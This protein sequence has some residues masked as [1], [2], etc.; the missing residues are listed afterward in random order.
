MKKVVVL[1]A[2]GSI[3]QQALDIIKSNPNEFE[4]VK[5]SIGKNVKKL[6]DILEI[7]PSIKEVALMEEEFI[8]DFNYGYGE[9]NFYPSSIG[10]LKL[11]N[12]DKYDYDI[13]VNG[14][15]GFAGLL[16]SLKTIEQDKILALANKETMV[17]AGDIVNQKLKDHPQAKIIPVDSEHCAIFQCLE[18]N[19][20]K[21]IKR[22]ILSASGGSFKDK[23]LEELENVSIEEALNHP[24]WQMGNAITIDSATMLNKALEIIEAHHL[25][26]VDYDQI[27]VVI[28]PQSI[29]H[30]MVEYKDSSILAQLSYP[31]MRQPIL[32]ALTYPNRLNFSE[33]SIDFSKPLNLNFEPVDLKRFEAIEL[34]FIVGRLGH[35]FPCVLNAS[36]EVATNA[37]LKGEISFLNIVEIVKKTI[38]FHKKVENPNIEQL[39]KIDKLTRDYVNLLIKKEF[40][41]GNN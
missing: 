5:I 12:K 41:N 7:F 18:N 24:N 30:S 38:K 20:H 34:A 19:N 40:V 26:K 32:Y 39:I 11:L 17:I 2:T 29:V 9:I 31:D 13:V 28:Q 23:S 3:G 15:V 35:S 27:E 10:I 1:G 6:L 33:N 8:E 37:F 36:K 4:L 22:L 16:P 25:F 14:I 21:D